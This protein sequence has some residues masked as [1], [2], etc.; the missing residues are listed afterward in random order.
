MPNFMTR[1]T[2]LMKYM[3]RLFLSP[4]RIQGNR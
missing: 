3:P 1:M 2:M 4:K